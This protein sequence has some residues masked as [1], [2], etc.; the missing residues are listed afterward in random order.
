MSVLPI[1]I[2]GSPLAEG[3]YTPQELFDAIVARLALETQESY[4]LIGTG[5]VLP[6]SDQGPFMLDGNKLYVW[7]ETDGEYQPQIIE[8]QADLNPK[9]FK[10]EL[11]ADQTIVLPGAGSGEADLVYTES[12]DPDS[13]YDSNTFIAPEDGFY[14]IKAKIS[15]AVTAGTPTDNILL[16]YPKKNGFQMPKEQVFVELGSVVVGRTLLIDTDIQ[17][18]AGD[19]ITIAVG[20]SAGGGSGTWTIYAQ[21]SWFSGH[22]IRNLTF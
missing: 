19:T 14:N 5:S 10:A 8:F 11:T 22:K 13:V 16:F 21:D 4:V 9:P 12:F 1:T 6:T 20:V 7:N 17:L 15:A 2:T 3:N 18:Q